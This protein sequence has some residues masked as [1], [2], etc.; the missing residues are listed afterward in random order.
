VHAAGRERDYWTPKSYEGGAFNKRFLLALA[1]PYQIIAHRRRERLRI[2]LQRR[3]SAFPHK[4]TVDQM[5]SDEA[6]ALWDNTRP[7]AYSTA[8][9]ILQSS[10]LRSFRMRAIKLELLDRL[11][12]RKTTVSAPNQRQRFVELFPALA[13]ALV[14]TPA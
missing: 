5:F 2:P 11:F 1:R 9:T 4:T 14:Q 13:Q 12:P 8:A 10:I 6:F 3:Y 7:S